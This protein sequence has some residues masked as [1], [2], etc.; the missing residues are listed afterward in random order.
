MPYPLYHDK[1]LKG[2]LPTFEPTYICLTFLLGTYVEYEMFRYEHP[3]CLEL[4]HDK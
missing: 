3:L 4:E 1:R 2:K